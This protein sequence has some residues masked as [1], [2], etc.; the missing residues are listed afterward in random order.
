MWLMP[1]TLVL[2]RQR[3]VDLYEFQ[4]SMVYL[5]SSRLVSAKNETLSS[6]QASKQTK[7]TPYSPNNKTKPPT[8]FLKK[9]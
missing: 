8:D 3:Q 7:Q 9:M 1:L 6:N 2:N 4:A 5:V